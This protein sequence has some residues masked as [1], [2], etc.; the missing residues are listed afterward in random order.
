M[1]TLV[2]SWPRTHA[3]LAS[4]VPGWL[5]LALALSAAAMLGLALVWW[6]CLRVFGAL[7]PAASAA[8][9][10]FGGEL[11]KY[12]PGGVW[13]VLGRGELARRSGRVG[14]STA[15]VT[16]LLSYGAMC[17]AAAMVC[18]VLGPLAAALGRGPA[19]GWALIALLPLAAVVHPRVL[20]RVLTL[21]RRITGGRVDLQAPPWR[22]TAVL[23]AWCVPAWL[24]LGAAAVA[25]TEALGLD[26]SPLRVALAAVLA[27]IV[28]FLAVPVPAGAGIRE[29][30]FVLLCGLPAAPATAVAVLARVLL[31]VVDAVGGIAGLA[32]SVRAPAQELR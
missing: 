4:A 22:R 17:L 21:G 31:V 24:L 9:W 27:W 13:T 16:T 6:R 1:R 30:L 5:V 18:G 25:V 11:G 3:A 15:Y 32:H 8:A 26:Q 19:W 14:R 28:G 12:L 10:Y 20:S 29:L 2:E 23:V 7:V